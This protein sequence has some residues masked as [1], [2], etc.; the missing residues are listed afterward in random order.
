MQEKTFNM[1]WKVIIS[2]IL[3]GNLDSRRQALVTACNLLK[4][5][6]DL[7]S[8]ESIEKEKF[9]FPKHM[10]EVKIVIYP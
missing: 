2:S 9:Y 3:R 5:Q 7:L 8:A 10:L 6:S 4:I 1:A